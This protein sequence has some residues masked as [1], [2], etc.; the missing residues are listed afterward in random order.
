MAPTQVEYLTI[1]VPAPPYTNSA[2]ARAHAVG[3]TPPTEATV[4]TLHVQ[5]YGGGGRHEPR[6]TGATV[7]PTILSNGLA[8]VQMTRVMANIPMPKYSGNLEDFDE[9]K[10]TWNKYVNDSI[11]GCNEAQRQHFC[12]S[13]LPHCVPANVKKELDDWDGGLGGLELGVITAQPPCR[14]SSSRRAL[15]QGTNR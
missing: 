13:M 3:P 5:K 2:N 15:G 9:F 14:T 10:R 4:N 12:L 11:M 1:E 7:T 8:E 6:A